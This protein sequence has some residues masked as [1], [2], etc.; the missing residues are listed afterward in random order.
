[1]F[2]A[3]Q[4]FRPA[5]NNSNDTSK[6]ISKSYVV[7]ENVKAILAKAC[8]DCHSNNTKYP[9]YAEI[10]PVAWWLNDHIQDGKKHLNFNEFDGY[11]I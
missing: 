1:L 2:V 11:R 5:K 3:A 4:A 8:N 6:D 9:W 10:Q 7:P